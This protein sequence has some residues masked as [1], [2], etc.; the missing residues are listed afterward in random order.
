MTLDRVM[1]RRPIMLVL[2]IEKFEIIFVFEDYFSCVG[3]IEIEKGF[4]EIGRELSGGIMGVFVEFG[5]SV[6]SR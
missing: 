3:K 2:S 1:K 4:V 5:V 6:E